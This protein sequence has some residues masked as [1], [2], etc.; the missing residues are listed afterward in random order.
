MHSCT[1]ILSIF[2]IFLLAVPRNA[3]VSG[4]GIGENDSCNT[5]WNHGV[6]VCSFVEVDTDSS[7]EGIQWLDLEIVVWLFVGAVGST[8]Q[9][10]LEWSGSL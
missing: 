5:T 4:S 3:F 9:R 7:L 10:S 8:R 2:L 1:L 6:V